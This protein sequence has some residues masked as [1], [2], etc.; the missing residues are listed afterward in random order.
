MN[1][2]VK[3]PLSKLLFGAA[4]PML[5]LGLAAAPPAYA[6]EKTIVLGA[7]V[8]LTGNLANSGRYYRDGYN[9]AIDA[10]NAKGGV[11][12]GGTKY[13]LA[14]NILDNQSDVNLGVRQYVQLVTRDKVN[15]LLGPFASNDALDDSVVAEKYKVPMVQGG[16]ASGQIYSRG[17]KYIF[18]TL[19]AAGDY[20]KSTI[21]MLMKLNPKPKTVALIAADDSFDVSV[22]AGT[23]PLLASAGL[24]VVADKQYSE[25]SPD[26]SSILSFVKSTSPDAILWTGHEPQAL[27]FIRQ[28]R[29]LDVNA[30][31]MSSYTVG[32]PSSDFRKALGPDADY[33]FGM[34][35]WLPLKTLTDPW[36]GDGM[37]FADAYQK[38]FGYPPDYHAAS[39]V[40][41]VEAFAKAIEAA[42]SLDSDKVRDALTKVDFQSLYGQVKFGSTGQISMPQSV[43]Q[44]QN[45]K[46]VPIY[47]TD[48]IEKPLY[49]T[50]VWSKRH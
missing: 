8:Q 16:G 1:R 36:F 38:R 22:A 40:A 35:P 50:P 19:P 39:A 29:S 3:L 11:N 12:V 13:K 5:A 43:I 23:R 9:L 31:L 26:F 27:S 30:G 34:T 41:D 14:L 10:I 20:F 4:M 6:Q 49:P 32:V 21:E 46:L 24:T 7:A 2:F 37:A 42:G 44:I 18:G 15:F 33:A 17:F 47:Q 45:G 48:F 28:A 25:N